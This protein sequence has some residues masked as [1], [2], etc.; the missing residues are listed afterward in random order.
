MAQY[1]APLRDMRF[2]MHEVLGLDAHYQALRALKNE[3]ANSSTALLENRR[4]SAERSGH[5]LNRTGDEEGCRTQHG[6]V[7]TP[8][9][10]RRPT[11]CSVELGGPA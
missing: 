5:P 8:K 10:F 1:K 6:V 11:K 4:K 2:V 9:G 7:R 3:A